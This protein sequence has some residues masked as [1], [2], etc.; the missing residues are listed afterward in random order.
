MHVHVYSVT[1]SGCSTYCMFAYVSITTFPLYILFMFMLHHYSMPI[2]GT[3]WCMY[4]YS[5]W[6]LLDIVLKILFCRQKSRAFND[7]VRGSQT[8]AP[9]EIKLEQTRSQL[10]RHSGTGEYR[11]ESS[12]INMCGTWYYALPTVALSWADTVHVHVA[13][14]S[15]GEILP[16]V[17]WPFPV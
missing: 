7:F 1:S 2:W 5:L 9:A 6:N 15:Q 16:D 13:H 11:S 10:P 4:M 3:A 14:M 8:A 12:C 17:V